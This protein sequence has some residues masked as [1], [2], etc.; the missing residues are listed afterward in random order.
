[1]VAALSL[2]LRKSRTN[3]NVSLKQKLFIHPRFSFC[4]MSFAFIPKKHPH[5]TS[6]PE[7][8]PGKLELSIESMTE[9]MGLGMN[10]QPFG[11]AYFAETAQKPKFLQSL[12]MSLQLPAVK[13][14]FFYFT[15]EHRPLTLKVT[16]TEY[17]KPRHLPPLIDGLSWLFFADRFYGRHRHEFMGVLNVENGPSFDI[18]FTYF[19]EL[20]QG[21]KLDYL[22]T[23]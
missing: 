13:K 3:Q 12:P 4:V 14:I 23:R 19:H 1:M 2:F 17:A 7:P 5:P 20:L 21:P 11:V 18:G 15:E 8:A 16:A 9:Q 22:R 10:P 6:N